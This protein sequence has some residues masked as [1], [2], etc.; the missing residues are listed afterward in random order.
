MRKIK[1]IAV[2]VLF[3][4]NA[5]LAVRFGFDIVTILALVLC[6]AVLVLDIVEG[7]SNGKKSV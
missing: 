5:V 6:G 1:S 4:A 3:V 2:L 7:V